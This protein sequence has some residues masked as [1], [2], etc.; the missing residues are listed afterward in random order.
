MGCT[1]FQRRALEKI[2]R[3]FFSS[4]IRLPRNFRYASKSDTREPVQFS[5]DGGTRT[6]AERDEIK[7]SGQINN[8]AYPENVL[9]ERKEHLC[10]LF[11]NVKPNKLKANILQTFQRRRSN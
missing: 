5:A 11:I 1:N 8:A 4:E 2:T 6:R 7:N 9:I 10:F 3:G